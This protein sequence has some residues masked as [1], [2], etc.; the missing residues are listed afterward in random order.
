M[1]DSIT[2]ICRPEIIQLIGFNL[3]VNILI[4]YNSQPIKNGNVNISIF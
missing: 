1:T 4:R 3:I 2:L